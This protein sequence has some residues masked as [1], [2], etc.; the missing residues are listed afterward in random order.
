MLT[1]L[2]YSLFPFLS[3]VS[4]QWIAQKTSHSNTLYCVKFNDENNGLISGSGV[5]ARTTNG[6]LDWIYT[7][8]DNNLFMLGR[9]YYCLDFADADSIYAGGQTYQYNFNGPSWHMPSYAKSVNGGASWILQ[10]TWTSWHFTYSSVCFVNNS[11]GWLTGYGDNSGGAVYKTTSGINN[12]KHEKSFSKKLYSSCFVDENNGWV[13]G[14]DGYISRT[15]DGGHN[16][17]ELNADTLLNLR[18]VKFIDTTYGMAVGYKSNPSESIVLK[19]KDGGK[20]WESQIL[21][22]KTAKTVFIFDRNISWIGGSIETAEG[23]KGIILYTADGGTNWEQQYIS[24]SSSSI[25]SIDFIDGTLGWAVGSNGEILKTATGGVTSVCDKT[26]KIKS[27]KLFQNYPN[28]FNPSTKISYSIPYR[29][30]V[31]LKVYDVL[32]NEVA[33]LVNGENGSGTYKAKFNAAHLAS[34]I[35]FYRLTAGNFVETK[36]MLLLR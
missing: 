12:F 13:C 17:I 33:T 14:Q 8:Q 16:W 25:N 15:R 3:T 36:K 20:N 31:A 29:S 7:D 26:N 4:A 2:I 24:D 27:F 1:I 6:G 23:N 21:N 30:Y 35:Y 18:S 34:G 32:G 5:L 28:P 19:T 10:K 11:T 22:L 9:T